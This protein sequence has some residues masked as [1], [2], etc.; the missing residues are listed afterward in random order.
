MILTETPVSITNSMGQFMM[1]VV[2]FGEFTDMEKLTCLTMGLDMQTRAWCP[3]LPQFE[4]VLPLAGQSF[5]E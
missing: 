4:H 3:I 2:I 5:L 1:Y